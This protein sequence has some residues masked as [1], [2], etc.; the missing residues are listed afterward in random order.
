MPAPTTI[1]ADGVFGAGGIR[2]LAI[3]GALLECSEN[4]SVR[5]E[6]WCNVAGTSGGAIIAALLAAG[7]TPVE[8]LEV[9]DRA[10]LPEFG[11][12]GRVFGGARNLIRRHGLTQGAH[13][14]KWLDNELDF[15]TF[16]SLRSPPVDGTEPAHP[17]R[18][19]VVAAD[20]TNRCML[21]LP[22]DLPKYRLLG[23]DEPIDPDKF[24]V[25][26]AVRMSFS[27]PFWVDPAHLVH[28]KTK[29]PATIVDGGVVSSFPVW[30]FDREHG[31]LQRPTLGIRLKPAPARRPL[32]PGPAWP[33][34]MA[35]DIARTPADAWDERFVTEADTVRTCMIDAGTIG[36]IS[37][38]ASQK[39][40]EELIHRGR[41]DAKKFLQ[42]FD[43]S[44]YRNSRGL[45]MT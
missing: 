10:P 42:E 44:Q 32:L 2:A 34:G 41:S 39:Q 37:F 4:E 24:R 27:I 25:A 17:Y 21:V 23:N 45:G 5:I 11:P 15:M 12:G 19:R 35:I 22:D 9:L 14:Q 1:E 20:I 30:L 38:R 6:R 36:S 13:L 16:G 26:H 18:L 8:L 31:K 29:R 33:I 43:L 40:R 28:V 7:R 3:A